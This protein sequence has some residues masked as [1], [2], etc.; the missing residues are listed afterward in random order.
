M[1]I[2]GEGVFYFGNQV[3]SFLNK[4]LVHHLYE[5]SIAMNVSSAASQASSVY[6][7]MQK[8]EFSFSASYLEITGGA[9][10]ASRA[11]GEDELQVSDLARQLLERARDL[12]VFKIICPNSDVSKPYKSLNDVEK[13]F[14]QDFMNFTGSFASMFAT[15]GLDGKN[16]T[17]GLNGTGGVDVGGEGDAAQKVQSAFN[18]SNTMVSRFAVM[19]ARAALVDART[20]VPGFESDYASDPVAAI[21]ANIGDLKDLLLGFRTVAGGE[22]MSYGFMRDVSINFEY[23]STTVAW[24]AAAAAATQETE[25][26]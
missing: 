9:A 1:H 8:A 5:R 11:G 7:S 25:A 24:G 18:G 10:K 2:P 23:S 16:L 3:A 22:G 15:L 13:D 6:A 19:A 12:D 14:N 20:S 26:A 17:M 21:K 4:E